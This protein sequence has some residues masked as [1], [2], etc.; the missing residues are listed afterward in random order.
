MNSSGSLS[1]HQ[2]KN[3]K[4]NSKIKTLNKHHQKKR[5]KKKRDKKTT[6]R[7]K[8]DDDENADDGPPGSG[9]SH[10]ALWGRR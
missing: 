9:E 2:K 10:D 1:L 6:H 4:K 8:N 7:R 3:T 5:D